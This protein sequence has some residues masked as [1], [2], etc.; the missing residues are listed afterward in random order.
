MHIRQAMKQIVFL[1]LIFLASAAWSQK[2][3]PDAFPPIA[4]PNEPKG[5]TMAGTVEEMYSWDR[6]PTYPVYV[7][8]MERFVDSFPSLCHLDTIAC[9]CIE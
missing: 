6:Y 2:P 4:D 5:L 1:L 8:M 3:R 9:C 7:A